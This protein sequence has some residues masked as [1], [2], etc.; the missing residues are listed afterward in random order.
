MNGA[1]RY[2][3]YYAYNAFENSVPNETKLRDGSLQNA[4]PNAL[5]T[6]YT[7]KP[8]DGVTSVTDP[9]KV[10]TYYEYDLFGRLET[11]KDHINQNIEGYEYRYK[12]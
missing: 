2:D 4:L 8:L 11:V 9:R 1:V 3:T 12:N 5:V 6:T 10:T 7:Y